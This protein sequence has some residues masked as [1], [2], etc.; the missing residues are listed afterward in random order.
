MEFFLK[1]NFV[2]RVCD[3]M[4]GK[5]SPLCQSG[6]KR[7]EMGGYYQPNF[8]PIVKILIKILTTPDLL[9]KYPLSE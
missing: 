4:L 3:F 7:V 6:E 5:K 9:E 2:E 1:I 8:T